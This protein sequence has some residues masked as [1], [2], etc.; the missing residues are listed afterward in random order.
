MTVSLLDL[1]GQLPKGNVISIK[2]LQVVFRA[3]MLL[4]NAK[5]DI[6]FPA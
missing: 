2:M 4:I 5:K 6:P 3:L 1:A